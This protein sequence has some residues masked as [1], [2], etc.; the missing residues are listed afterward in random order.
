LLDGTS[1]RI[2]KLQII[3]P[4]STF[5]LPASVVSDVESMST[6]TSSMSSS[7]AVAGAVTVTESISTTTPVDQRTERGDDEEEPVPTTLREAFDAFLLGQHHGPR[8][9][10]AAIAGLAVWR[11][12]LGPVEAVDGLIFATLVVFWWLQEHVLHKHALHSRWDWPGKEIHREHHAK[13]YSHVSID[14]AP[15]MLGWLGCAALILRGT[16]PP[17]LALSA[18]LGYAAAGLFYEWAHYVVHTKVRFPRG[19]YW[20]RMKHHQYVPNPLGS[21]DTCCGLLLVLRFLLF[22]SLAMHFLS[23]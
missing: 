23:L 21:V 3:R 12:H 1:A 14:P 6:S 13:P 7:R 17:Q 2:L 22:R 11:S 19:S 5:I 20:Y 18:T 10:I 4:Q 15:L 9:V 8:L 16:L